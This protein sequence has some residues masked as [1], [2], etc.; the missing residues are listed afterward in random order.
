[1]QQTMSSSALV[2]L[3]DNRAKV[4]DSLMGRARYA[5]S[6]R[7]I[8]DSLSVRLRP[9]AR[10]L[11]LG[12]GTGLATAALADRFSRAS[13]VGVDCSEQMLRICHAKF[14]GVELVVG[15]FN[16]GQGLRSFTSGR[17]VRLRDGS[18]DLIISTGAV[19]EYGLLDSVV[20]MVYSLLRDR[21]VF[22]NIGIK[23]NL[24]N[25]MSGIV[26]RFHPKS[27]TR[28]ISACRDSGF[29]RVDVISIPWKLFPTNCL[30]Y[31]VKAVKQPLTPIRP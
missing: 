9:R 12:C 3:Y 25:M 2:R 20:P 29:A 30:K 21:G 18:F 8:I 31:A 27:R 13:I 5:S 7:T 19:S 6:I 1:M 4:Y 24:I 14:P 26:W 11:D 10:I 17:R 28:F 22:V 15:D 23:R 16:N